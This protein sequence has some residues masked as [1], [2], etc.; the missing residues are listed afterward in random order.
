M[1]K[2]PQGARAVALVILLPK[3]EQAVLHLWLYTSLEWENTQIGDIL[4]SPSTPGVT[5]P[6]FKIDGIFIP[7]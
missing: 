4:M 1:N 3:G 6:C 7:I 5:D 2:Q